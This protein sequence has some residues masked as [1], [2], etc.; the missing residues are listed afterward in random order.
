[1][2]T[3]ATEQQAGGRKRLLRKGRRPS[4][5]I[6]WHGESC[7]IEEAI[8]LQMAGQHGSRRYYQVLLQPNR[9]KLVEEIAAE[10]GIRATELIRRM[11]YDWLER[12]LP[13][14][15]YKQALA[16]DQA[17]WAQAVRNRVEGRAKSKKES[18]EQVV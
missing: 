7:S 4:K 5:T 3:E 17:V 15:Q 13:A 11:T 1:M 10:K 9:A 14:S 6:P 8:A 18:K 2:E 12:E 16:E